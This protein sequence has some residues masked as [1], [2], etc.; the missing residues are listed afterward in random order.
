L[1]VNILEALTKLLVFVGIF[2]KSLRGIEH[3]VRALAVG[4]KLEERTKFGLVQA[5]IAFP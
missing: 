1:G 5:S 2:D 3:N 4:Q